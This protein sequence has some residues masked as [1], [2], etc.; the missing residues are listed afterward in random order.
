MTSQTGR[1]RTAGFL[2]LGQ[3][4]RRAAAVNIRQSNLPARLDRGEHRHTIQGGGTPPPTKRSTTCLHRHLDKLGSVDSLNP[5]C[6]SGLSSNFRQIRPIVEADRPD[7][8]AIDTRDQWVASVA[9]SSSVAV[10]TCSTWSSRI[11]GGRPGRG[12]S[13]SP[14]S[15][16]STNRVR[17]FATV[18][19]RT[20]SFAA[21]SIF[22]EPS[23]HANTILDRNA[24]ASAAEL[25][26][27]AHRLSSIP[28]RLGQRQPRLRPA[29]TRPVDQ[30]G[31][32]CPRT[33]SYVVLRTT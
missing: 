15:R 2:H 10:T 22:D 5:S 6:R 27:R 12:S 18:C 13:T 11:D 16:L 8:C 1:A 23:A 31:Q 28:L 29:R 25:D 4:R 30:S 33:T 32:P 9:D 20:L 19:S 21:T 3:S 7:R 14:S 26:R 17:H 24:N